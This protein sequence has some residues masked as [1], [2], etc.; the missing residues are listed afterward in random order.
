[1]PWVA[2]IILFILVSY[3]PW[4]LLVPVVLVIGMF[5]VKLLQEWWKYFIEEAGIVSETHADYM[6]R[7]EKIRQTCLNTQATQAINNSRAK[8]TYTPPTRT[9]RYTEEDVTVVPRARTSSPPPPPPPPPLTG[10]VYLLK[11]GPHY[12]IGKAVEF[13]KRIKQLK[14]QLP[15]AIEVVHKIYAQNPSVAESQWHKRFANKRV[16]GEWFTL[17]EADVAEFKSKSLM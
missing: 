4:L 14:I 6:E 3:Y 1:M 10:G 16:N 13:D 15:F 17:T 7:T 8:T 2:I 12:K 11:A 5:V 9:I